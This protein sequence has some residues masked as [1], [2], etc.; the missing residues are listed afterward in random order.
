AVT[1]PEGTVSNLVVTDL[2][3]RGMQ[4]VTNRVITGGFGGALGSPEGVISNGSSGSPVSLVFSNYTVVTSNN[5]TGDNTFW[6]DVDG[7]VLNTNINSGLSGSQA[8]FTNKAA[9][10]FAGNSLA[11]VTNLTAVLVTNVEPVIV[12][13][14]TFSTNMMDAGDVVTVTLVVTNTG[15]ATAFDLVVTD[16]VDTAYFSTN[17]SVSSFTVNTLPPDGYVM[18]AIPGGLLITSDASGSSAPTNSLEVREG[19]TFSYQLKAAQT[20]QPNTG[21]SLAASFR[22]DTMAGNPSEQRVVSAADSA[23]SVSI[24]TI[25][26]S[27]SLAGT[28]LTHDWE[29]AGSNLQIGET[30]TYRIDVTLP[31][32]TI[33]NLVVTDLIPTGMK[34]TAYRLFVPAN[35]TLGA[36]SVTGGALSGD[37]VIITFSG[38]TVVL[39]NDIGSDNTLGIEVDALVLDAPLNHGLVGQQTAFT[40]KATAAFSGPG[41]ST[42]N[43][44]EVYTRAVEPSLRM[45]K[46]M[47]GPV[48]GLVTVSLVVTNA[49][50]ATAY[51]IVVT[52]R[53]DSVYFDTTTL[54][55]THLPVGFTFS[56]NGAPG[57][58]TLMLASDTGSENPTNAI[59]AGEAATFTFTLQSVPNAGLSITNV[60]VIVSNSTLSGSSVLERV[61]PVVTGT[62]VLVLPMSMISKTVSNPVANVGETVSYV[63]TV[64]N[65]GS[66]GMS[67]VLVRDFYPTNY[68]TYLNATPSPQT[69][70]VGGTLV[71]SNVG[72]VAVG[73]AANITVNFSAL[74]N[75]LPGV[76]TN[77]VNSEVVTT[78][79]SSPATIAGS[80]TNGIVPS[81]QLTKSVLFPVGR[82]AVT[83]G[84]AN[85]IMTVT[86]SGDVPLSS[87]RL[88]DSYDTNVLQFTSAQRAIS[89]GGQGTLAWNDLGSLAVGAVASVTGNFKAVTSTGVGK[90]T[91]TVISSAVFQSFNGINNLTTLRTNL[92]DLQVT[93]PVGLVVTFTNE[94]PAE[95]NITFQITTVSGAVYHVISVS[96][97]IDHPYGQNFRLMATWSN[98]PTWVTYRDTNVVQ[99]VSN[100]RFYHIVWEEAGVVQTNPVMYEAFVQN[101]TT[102][103]WH[104]LSM[105]VECYDYKLSG[106]LGTKLATGLT[107]TNVNGDL[108]FALNSDGVT[109]KTYML[110]NAR[111]WTLSPVGNPDVP[112]TDAVSPSVGY[113]IKRQTGG[114]STNIDYDGPVRLTSDPITF[115]PG[116]WRMISWPFPRSRREDYVV[117]GTNGWGFAKAGAHGDNNWRYA[118]RLYVGGGTNTVILYMRPNGRWYTTAEQSGA[119]VRLQHGVGYYYYHSGDG[120]TWQAVSP[121]PA[122]ETPGNEW[123][124]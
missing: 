78:L 77:L 87:I 61:E 95:S 96:N 120:F 55:N 43:S 92:A 59:K 83:N 15:L 103:Y 54:T 6:I 60:A 98:M 113:W 14:K 62:N 99:E 2:M 66:L 27:K 19:I 18:R 47:S 122:S 71:W 79:G 16:A 70:L 85:F 65:L 105:P 112:T 94:L 37:P 117:D 24:P 11:P 116:T 80:A 75:T 45:L 82:S 7:V 23:A 88:D 119:A 110:N 41:A 72:P 8:V 31:E 44:A 69:N 48:N 73:A 114:V 86:N 64:T 46:T 84:P 91:N 9:V 10:S 97:N 81:Y 58:V 57:A 123:Y 13:H 4:Y 17:N 76:M 56:S 107:G 63:I 106:T 42:L 89:S 53:L 74:H 50:L 28:S 52:D 26:V 25:S 68:V 39:G 3:P 35:M 124:K 102:G 38:D 29:S 90:T 100:T 101:F 34:Y 12:I 40:N 20:V 49:G 32:G 5:N 30:A 67:T 104:E 115:L 93:I 51:D 1:L 22:A 111:K 109:W 108:L 21:I 33:N 118:D 121:P 36:N